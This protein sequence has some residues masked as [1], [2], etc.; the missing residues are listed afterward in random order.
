[1]IRTLSI[2]LAA[3]V[4]IGLPFV[5]RQSEDVGVWEAGDPV[6]VIL[7][8]HN[9]AIRYEFARAFSAWHEERYGEPVKVDWRVIGG[10]SEIMRYLEAEYVA[11]FR[12]Y[13]RRQGRP[14]P[15]EAARVIIDRRFNPDR[16]PDEAAADPRLRAEWDTLVEI[17]RA[18]RGLDDPEAFGSQ[19]DL[20]FGGGTYDHGKAK[21]EGVTVAPWP[22][23]APPSN[24]LEDAEGRTLI[25]AEIGGE[26]W[27]DDVMFGTAVSTFGIVYNRDRLEQL[28]VAQPPARWDDLTHPAYS[29]QLGVADPTKSGSIAK[30]FEMMIHQKIDERLR[31]EGFAEEEIERYEAAITA[32]GLPPGEVPAGV[33]ADYQAAV[34]AGWIDGLRL[35]Q[36]I[37]AN[38]RYFTDA[39]GK[40]PIDVSTGDAAV[41]IAIDFYGRYQ[42][43][44]SRGPKGEERMFYVTP[45]GGSSVSADPI[46][47]L[48]GAPHRELAV[49]F[50]TFV[51]RPEGQRLWTYATGTPGGPAKFALRRLPIRRDF[52]PSDDPVIQAAADRHARF[53]VDDLGDPAV[54]PYALAREF[55]YRPRWTARHF[56][57]HRD[58]IRAMCLD[59]AHELKQAWEMIVAHGGPDALPEAMAALQRLPDTPAP[60]TWRTARTVTRS[61]PRI[62]YMREWTVFFRRS[63][64]EA[65]RLAGEGRGPG[66]GTER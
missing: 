44:T 58:L 65:R 47:L 49:R 30:A 41:G 66:G 1:M 3:A 32:A 7:S 37:G 35:V 10:T 4:V 34:E 19:I 60:I 64:A 22:A 50:M 45:A 55:T 25:P 20:F 9:E 61:V 24:T 27:R 56:N 28:G 46:S 43:E 11:A 15:P 13:W 52:Y 14:W 6:L 59:S 23:E 57:V 42:A 54:N 53:A 21:G 5:F 29:R 40:V 2:L 51:L 26:R 12:G 48:R 39:A 63:Y 31:A 17:Y 8:P 33:P 18:F 62:D 38:A 16:M 36:R